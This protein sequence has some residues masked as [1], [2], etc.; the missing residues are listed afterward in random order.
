VRGEL[1]D[2]PLHVGARR[3]DIGVDVVAEY[4]GPPRVGQG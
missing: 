3:E 4:P 1:F 2:G